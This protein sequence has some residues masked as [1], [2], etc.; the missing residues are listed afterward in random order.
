MDGESPIWLEDPS[1]K[2]MYAWGC[3]TWPRQLA[4]ILAIS[5][6][7]AQII[8]NFHRNDDS[9]L[10]ETYTVTVIRRS[11]ILEWMTM[12]IWLSPNNSKWK[13]NT[14]KSGNLGR[15]MIRMRTVS[16]RHPIISWISL[17]FK[18]LVIIGDLH[19]GMWLYPDE[20]R[21]MFST[22]ENRV[23]PRDTKE[24]E[25]EKAKIAHEQL[26]DQVIF[27]RRVIAGAYDVNAVYVFRNVN[28]ANAKYS[29][30]PWTSRVRV[31]L[32]GFSLHMILQN[33]VTLPMPPMKK[34]MNR[35]AQP[36]ERT[37]RT[38]SSMG[39]SP[40]RSPCACDCW[41]ASPTG[42]ASD[43]F[44]GKSIDSSAAPSGTSSASR[45]AAKAAPKQ[46]PTPPTRRGTRQQRT[47][48]W[49]P[50]IPPRRRLELYW[51][52]TLVKI[53]TSAKVS[54]DGDKR[55]MPLTIWASTFWEESEPAFSFFRL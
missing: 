39:H 20:F 24:E 52:S 32:I 3:P 44:N 9:N 25:E 43:S 50:W 30:T 55:I 10:L 11:R 19:L 48:R 14:R 5:T 12:E 15:P 21:E 6:N 29:L 16:S 38:T 27:L 33:G 54:S 47:D 22:K 1:G 49:I 45:P 26:E 41:H 28:Y 35:W 53:S 8:K 40:E 36:I 31:E 42:H 7:I 23:N 17:I 2:P 13:F 51:R 4:S 37:W 18:P 46:P 34:L